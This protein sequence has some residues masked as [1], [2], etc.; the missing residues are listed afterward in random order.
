MPAPK[1]VNPTLMHTLFAYNPTTGELEQKPPAARAARKINRTQWE[2]G[3]HKYS[4]HRIIWAMHNPDTPNPQVVGFRDGN[5]ANTRIE[6]LFATGLYARGGAATDGKPERL[7]RGMTRDKDT[8]KIF[9]SFMH[10]GVMVSL[11]PFDTTTQAMTAKRTYAAPPTTPELEPTQ[12][13]EPEAIDT[14][15]T[16]FIAELEAQMPP[17]VANKPAR[18]PTREELNAIYDAIEDKKF[19]FQ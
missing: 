15:D 4:V 5:T 14:V 10:D 12:P 2:I 9:M 18:K 19:D 16:S 13:A 8:G 17:P 1:P 6:N 7:V 11:G 3:P